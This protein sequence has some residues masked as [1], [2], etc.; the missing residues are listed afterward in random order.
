MHYFMGFQASTRVDVARSDG[1][2]EECGIV[3]M[4]I[5]HDERGLIPRL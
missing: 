3:R 1:L 2:L 4:L 5:I